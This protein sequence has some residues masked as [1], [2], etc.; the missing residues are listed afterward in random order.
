MIIERWPAATHHAAALI[1]GVGFSALVGQVPLLDGLTYEYAV[2]VALALFAAS[3]V[4]GS[5]SGRSLVKPYALRWNLLEGSPRER[6]EPVL[7]R[8]AVMFALAAVAAMALPVLRGHGGGC[9]WEQGIGLYLF[10]TSAAIPLGLAIG[11]LARAVAPCRRR[12]RLA[13]IG[14]FVALTV[15][16]TVYE[17][18]AGPR[19]VFH[20]L[21]VGIVSNTAYLGLDES[22]RI[23]AHDVFHRSAALVLAALLLAVALERAAAR[24]E[25]APGSDVDRLHGLMR[26]ERRS[27][28]RRT[29]YVGL[30]LS[31]MV[32]VGD[33]FGFGAGRTPVERR[34]SAAITTDHFVLRYRP[35][36]RVESVARLLADDCEWAH[37]RLVR[38]L[39]L[40]A[41]DGQRIVIWVYT[42]DREKRELTGASGYL[43]AKPWLGEI[44]TQLGPAG[45]LVA[46]EHE[47]VHVLAA[48]FGLPLLRVSTRY[49]L[50]EGLA[51]GVAGHYADRPWR[52]EPVA[53][54]LR[55]GLLP[56]AAE[57]IG[58]LG[59]ASLES[60]TSY[61]SAASF[62]GFLLAR[63]GSEPL[64]E[65]YA[66][67]DFE[68][69]YQKSLESL[70]SEWRLFLRDIPVGARAE[71]FAQRVFD[72]ELSPPFFRKACARLGLR[73]GA[74]DRAR[75]SFDP[76]VV[77]ERELS[78]LDRGAATGPLLGRDAALA[79]LA[80]RLAR[81]DR[82]DEAGAALLRRRLLGV[83]A[84][85][86]Q[87][88]LEALRPDRM[89]S[90]IALTTGRAP[91]E[92]Q[93]D[94]ARVAELTRAVVDDASL[95]VMIE[96]ALLV[97]GCG[98][99]LGELE[100]LYLLR[101]ARA[102]RRGDR[103]ADALTLARRALALAP[104]G[105][106]AALDAAIEIARAARTARPTVSF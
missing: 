64:R 9:R 88:G 29:L 97:G 77:R 2:V 3:V 26:R 60:R 7:G 56:S 55:A 15:A 92:L 103:R 89:A 50:I 32:A 25:F 34:L 69:V 22:V 94:D 31:A 91:A 85:P 28:R 35:G 16:L 81:D 104:R 8:W 46:L 105:S 45:D 102:A 71:A 39:E 12:W 47:I 62:C 30:I 42:D 24:A 27:A 53:A 5:A 57:L 59:F 51:E 90:M 68:R 76:N 33:P 17:V 99:E 40:P 41:G 63:Y 61:L 74:A 84:R 80:T 37:E 43:F 100:S 20:N 11:V 83:A 49:G 96:R 66:R 65:V 73:S 13:V 98:A 75:S 106:D 82:F 86:V 23:T 18:L 79:A 87:R 36:S 48:R 38:R 67:G 21:I 78:R 52:H 70:D 4:A 6:L 58:T 72:R 44:H 14:G 10:I 101:V 54:A 95:E 19:A 1:G 93:D